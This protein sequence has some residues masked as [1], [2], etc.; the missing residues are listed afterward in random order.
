MDNPTHTRDRRNEDSSFDPPET[1]TKG[2]GTVSLE[3]R[4]YEDPDP[5]P[6]PGPGTKGPGTVSLEDRSYEDP[7]P[8]PNPGPG[9]KGPGTVGLNG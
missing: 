7:D 5:G 1:G 6:N 8:G 3:D 2:P 9:T 4:S